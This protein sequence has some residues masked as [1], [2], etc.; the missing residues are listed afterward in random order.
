MNEPYTAVALQTPHHSCQTPQDWD[1]NASYY[2]VVKLDEVE[3]YI[4]TRRKKR[5][6]HLFIDLLELETLESV[7]TADVQVTKYM[8]R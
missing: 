8:S 5:E 7:F 3:H 2:L 4:T 6:F 1:I